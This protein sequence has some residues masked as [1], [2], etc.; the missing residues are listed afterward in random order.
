[1]KCIIAKKFLFSAGFC[2]AVDSAPAERRFGFS[3]QKRFRRR[4]EGRF[5]GIADGSARTRTTPP[6]S[7]MTVIF[8][9]CS[10]LFSLPG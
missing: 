6:R 10:A 9:I 3:Q 7:N 4:R 8:F 5:L 1:V 2:P